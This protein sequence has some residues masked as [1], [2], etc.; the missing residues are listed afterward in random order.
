MKR[1]KLIKDLPNL[2]KGT[3]LSEHSSALGLRILVTESK[4]VVTNFI[5]N[6]IFEKF[7]EEIEES[8]DS[9]HWKPKDGEKYWFLDENGDTNFACFDRDDPSDRKLLEFGNA[10]RTAQE[11]EKARERKLAK[12]RLQRTSTF[13]PDFINENGGFTVYYDPYRERLYYARNAYFNSG[14]PVRYETREDALKS[15]KENREDWLIYFGIE[16]KE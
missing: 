13:E 16:E 3:I 11:C 12:V 10:Y 5:S 6:D 15:I 1:Y 9:I 8:T 4:E 2:E 7:F 14:E